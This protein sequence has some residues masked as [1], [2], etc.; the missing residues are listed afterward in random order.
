MVICFY[1]K[2]RR[3]FT[4]RKTG[5]E[6]PTEIAASANKATPLRAIG[7]NID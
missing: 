3:T 1:S 6:A 4:V 5:S 2:K 7:D